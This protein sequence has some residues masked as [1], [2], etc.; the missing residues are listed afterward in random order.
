MTLL[1]LRQ[2]NNTR[3]V[4]SQFQVTLCVSCCFIARPLTK[5]FGEVKEG[6]LPFSYLNEG[7]GWT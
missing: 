4:G 3:C 6:F 2:S 7:L 5:K 1:A